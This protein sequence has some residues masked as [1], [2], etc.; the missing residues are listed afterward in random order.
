MWQDLY[1]NKYVQNFTSGRGV[2]KPNDPLAPF[3]VDTKSTPWNA[4]LCR[5]V[6][7]CGYTYPELQR[8]LDIYKTNGV[9]DNAKYTKALRTS[10]ELKYSTTGKSTLQLPKFEGLADA[11]LLTLPAMNLAVENI[12]PV[13]VAKA[14]ELQAAAEGAQ[15][16]L[17][18]A[19]ITDSVPAAPVPGGVEKQVPIA[20][21]APSAAAFLTQAS[22]PAQLPGLALVPSPVAREKWSENDYIVNVLF[23]RYSLSQFILVSDCTD[24][25]S[26]ASHS[27][28]TPTASAY[29]SATFPRTGSLFCSPTRQTK[30]ALCTTSVLL[31]NIVVS[32]RLDVPT[33]FVKRMGTSCRLVR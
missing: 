25:F 27:K 13:L 10:I 16:F 2:T 28:A 19:T 29:S 3:H 9:F 20:Q 1:P 18:A 8:W 32:P 17:Q 26:T 21:A 11:H 4:S 12:P 7:D 6:K 5:Y 14:V 31:L 15:P 22:S 33:A 24:F 30:S 23:D